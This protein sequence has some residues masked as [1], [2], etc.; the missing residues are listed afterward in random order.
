MPSF[1]EVQYYLAGLWLLI[2]MDA[3]G[4][5]YLDISDRGLMRSFWAFIWCLPPM[6]ISWMWWRQAYLQLMPVNAS[7]GFA[8]F[9]RLALVEVA[10]WL[11]PLILAGFLLMV[12]R[13]GE[14]FVPIVVTTN[15]LSVP[16]SYLN[17][18][19]VALAAF[20]PGAA[21][22]VSLLWLVLMMALIFI[23]ARV[24]RMI[25]GAQPLTVGAITLVLVVP[26]MILS[27]F[28]QGFLGL[29]PP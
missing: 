6:G 11:V 20:V 29:S 22:L 2:R 19:L 16:L 17:A 5:S 18:L 7:A 14:R 10:N 15:W 25:C 8:F 12:L 13:I 27:E 4:F 3:R 28:L 1:K 21:G 9:F 23:L 26:S 24:L